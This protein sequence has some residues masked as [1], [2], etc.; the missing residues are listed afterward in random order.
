MIERTC[1]EGMMMGRIGALLFAAALGGCATAQ[2]RIT[3][4]TPAGVE[5][6]CIGLITCQSPQAVADAAQA[7]CQ[8]YG[9]DAQQR[10]VVRAPS[11]NE[12]AAYNCVKR[13]A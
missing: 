12:V 5:L 2:P 10:A 6:S 3:A 4:A 8:R 1:G 11:G 9:L 7:H 13:G